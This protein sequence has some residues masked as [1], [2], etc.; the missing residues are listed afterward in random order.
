MCAQLATSERCFAFDL[1]AGS[2][3]DKS[4]ML[5][6]LRDL[7]QNAGIE[8]VVHN[9][10]TTSAVL[11]SEMG[12]TPAG[13]WDTQVHASFDPAVCHLS[14]S[15]SGQTSARVYSFLTAASLVL[16][17]ME[18]MLFLVSIILCSTH[19][20]PRAER[21]TR[22]EAMSAARHRLLVATT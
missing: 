9:A 2:L 15:A 19:L 13:I 5:G 20:E 3:L 21:K 1:L 18:F 12:I 11:Q 6:H 16:A 4:E 7:L 14:E 10:H 22:N 8:K 17:L